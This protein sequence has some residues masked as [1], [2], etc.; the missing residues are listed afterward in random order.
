MSNNRPY[1]LC[2]SQQCTDRRYE[3]DAKMQRILDQ[4]NSIKEMERQNSAR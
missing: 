2:G 3:K 4:E 1:Y